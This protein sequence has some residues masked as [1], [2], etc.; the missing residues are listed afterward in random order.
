MT[1]AAISR[2]QTVTTSHIIVFEVTNIWIN[3]V[4]FHRVAW[5]LSL[6]QES[7]S[8]YD[9]GSLTWRPK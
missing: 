2:C 8:G 6:A 5:H 1:Y 7:P 3:Q 9:D 4:V